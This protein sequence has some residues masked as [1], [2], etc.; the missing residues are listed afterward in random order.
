MYTNDNFMRFKDQEV[1]KATAIERLINYMIYCNKSIIIGSD[2]P[3]ERM[4]QL[5]QLFPEARF[6]I[7]GMGVRLLNDPS[8]I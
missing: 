3:K 1:D 2:K 5:Q 6:E 8:R 7:C 4:K